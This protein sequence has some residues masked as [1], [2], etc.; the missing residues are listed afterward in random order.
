M[1][2]G[3]RQPTSQ[4]LEAVKPVTP[5]HAPVRSR[6][7]WPLYGLGVVLLLAAGGAYY[8]WFRPGEAPVRYVTAAVTQGDV[9]RSLTASGTVNPETTIQVG[10]YVSGVIQQV[11]CDFNTKVKAGQLCAKIDPRPFQSTVDQADANLKSAQAQLGK[12]QAALAYAQ[13]AAERNARL[14]KQGIVSQ[15]IAD[16]SKAAYDQARAEIAV[17]RATIVQRQAALDA[18]KINLAYTDIVSPVDGTVV[19]RNVTVGQTVA[20]TLQSPTLFLIATDLTKMQVDANVSESDIGPVK[21]GNR[22]TFTVQGFP[23]VTF[24]GQV[25]QVRQAPITLQN[26]VTYDV[27]ISVANPELLL[28]PGMTATARIITAERKNVLRAPDQALHYTPAGAGPAQ[29]QRQGQGQQAQGGARRAASAAGGQSRVYV[30]R[31]G[32]PVAVPVQVG[33]DDDAHA[34]ILSG[35]LKAGDAVIVSETRQ[36]GQSG[37]GAS[38]G[39][40]RGGQPRF[41]F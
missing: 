31:D 10:S 37:R 6:R 18:A 27:V 11:N 41:G 13:G 39:G 34:E 29:A 26:V 17:D 33:L 22:A 28:K 40:N 4:R 7:R 8:T 21:A 30:L 9:A 12:D 20:A 2:E 14:V 19:S 36:G 24:E 32:E 16:S 1:P 23:N 5:P 3:E 25:S 15:D 35:D 38:G